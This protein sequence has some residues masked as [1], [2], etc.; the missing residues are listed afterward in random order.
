MFLTKYY[1][2]TIFFSKHC[3][4]CVAWVL[5]ITIVC[6]GVGCDTGDD[7]VT[8]TE[9][10]VVEPTVPTVKVVDRYD[11]DSIIFDWQGTGHFVEARV[12]E[13]V[14]EDEVLVR[15]VDNSKEVISV[16]QI[17]GTLI[18]DHPDLGT[19]VVMLSEQEGEKIM[20]GHIVAVYDNGVRKIKIYVVD[21]GDGRSKRLE[22]PRIRLVH[23]DTH[24]G[25]GGY[26][27]LEEFA[28]F[29]AN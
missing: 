8:P 3:L 10:E 7:V 24:I 11:G 4:W 2:S 28:A 17:V 20:R 26:W 6:V 13:G 14:S 15:L 25:D 16:D 23:E 12:I 18:D 5:C 29:I 22:I 19:E 9:P 21:F 1:R 27:T